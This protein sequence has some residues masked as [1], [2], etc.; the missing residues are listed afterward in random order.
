[1]S[2]SS[3]EHSGLGRYEDSLNPWGDVMALAEAWCVAS[4]GARLVLGVPTTLE[5]TGSVWFNAHRIYGKQN[6]PYL[7]KVFYNK[8]IYED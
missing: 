3:V 6:Y 2:Y 5:N 1:M 4:P 7:V 8:K